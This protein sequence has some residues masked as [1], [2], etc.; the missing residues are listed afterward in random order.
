MDSEREVRFTINNIKLAKTVRQ[1][2]NQISSTCGHYSILEKIEDD[3]CKP[4][5]DCGRAECATSVD[6]SK[7]ICLDRCKVRSKKRTTKFDSWIHLCL[8][9]I[10]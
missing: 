3:K 9:S 4:M 8:V 7:L 5:R 10:E 2:S 6:N 1:L